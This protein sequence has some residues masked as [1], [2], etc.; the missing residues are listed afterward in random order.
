MQRDLTAV[1]ERQAAV[2]DATDA[3]G[4]SR[5]TWTVPEAARRLG[6]SVSY[7]YQCA[8]EGTLPVKKLGRRYVVPKDALRRF[9]EGVAS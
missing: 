7:Y 1:P 9:L 6:I 8:R 2:A 5:L 3:D 4:D